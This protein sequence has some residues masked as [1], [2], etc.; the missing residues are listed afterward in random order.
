VL[1]LSG[2]GVG[3]LRPLRGL[4][5]L[6][7]EPGLGGLA[8]RGCAAT[9]LDPRLDEM[10][11]IEDNR[12]RARTLFDHLET[13]EPPV[14][15][16]QEQQE[17][18]LPE[19]RPAPVEVEIAEGRVVLAAPTRGLAG[20]AE[21]RAQAGWEALR[22]F[23]DDV[24]ATLV[25]ANLPSL[26][27]AIQAFGRALGTR[28]EEVRAIAL[29]THGLRIVA[30]AR[31]ARVILVEE[32]AADLTAFAE[33]ITRHLQR[34]PDWVGYLQ[35][36]PM[37]EGPPLAGKAAALRELAGAMASDPI[38]APEVAE[39]FGDLVEAA[40]DAVVAEPV[41]K[42]GVLGSLSNILSGKLRAGLA[43]VRQYGRD[44]TSEAYKDHTKR[45]GKVVAYGVE[46]SVLAAAGGAFD[47]LL[48]KG[49]LL[50]YLAQKYPTWLGWLEPLVRLI[51]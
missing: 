10:S 50:L 17:L 34:F 21:R 46:F 36:L 15:P 2:T 40:E 44:V 33:A 43:S 6:A 49:Q 5:R 22:E 24:A 47:L 7:D 4:R 28:P 14:D 30:I 48:N 3:D 39:R 11:R 35:D 1:D 13:W 42:A 16:A 37:P 8:F 9:R 41:V 32:K 31:E 19:Q 23:H 51:L 18:T 12:E 38:I 45:V 25:L 29:G 27:R 20:D 26:T